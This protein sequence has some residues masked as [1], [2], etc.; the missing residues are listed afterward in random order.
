MAIGVS[1]SNQKKKISCYFL[2]SFLFF[3]SQFKVLICVKQW[4][5]C[6]LLLLELSSKTWSLDLEEPILLRHRAIVL[7][8]T[9]TYFKH[10]LQVYRHKFRDKSI[11]HYWVF[12]TDCVIGLMPHLDFLSCSIM[13]LLIWIFSTLSCLNYSKLHTVGT[14]SWN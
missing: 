9:R 11:N 6:I 14:I 10:V 4:L 1:Q 13:L 12:M 7:I 3:L 2:S 8:S 5:N